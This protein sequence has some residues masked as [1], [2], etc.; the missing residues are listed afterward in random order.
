MTKI[1]TLDQGRRSRCSR[2][3]DLCSSELWVGIGVSQLVCE[4][5]RTG[6]TN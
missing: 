2:K 4:A 3:L 6:I 1:G 5:A